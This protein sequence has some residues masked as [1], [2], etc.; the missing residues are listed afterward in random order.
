MTLFPQPDLIA[1]ADPMSI[2]NP[3]REEL[4]DILQNLA[5]A[6]QDHNLWLIN[7]H[8]AIICQ[9]P[10]DDHQTSEDAHRHCKF[11]RWYYQA[12][13]YLERFPIAKQIEQLHVG[14][15]EMA[16]CLLQKGVIHEPIFL[17]EYD[18]F[19]EL[20]EEFRDLVCVL[21]T[22]L[23][24]FLLH[25][26]ALTHIT[27]QRRLLPR[28]HQYKESLETQQMNGVVC[29]LNLEHL[30]QIC[31]NYGKAAEDQFVASFAH[32]LATH[33]RV[34]DMIVRSSEEVFMVVLT[35]VSLATAGMVVERLRTTL[36]NQTIVLDKK[37]ASKVTATFFCG[38]ASLESGLTVEESIDRAQADAITKISNPTA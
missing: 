33:L 10:L 20:R 36:A 7:W 31:A 11:G 19:L 26:D 5:L 12:S 37:S 29:L 3:N 23:N 6:V 35:N 30:P 15:H 4:Q 9:L 17:A 24:G 34:G 22:E 13:R 8:R 21:E 32:F 2:I 18:N 38:M 25:V 28:L 27:E 1:T 14:M 16:R